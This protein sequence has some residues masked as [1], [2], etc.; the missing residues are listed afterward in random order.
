LWVIDS[1]G[2]RLVKIANIVGRTITLI[3]QSEDKP[4]I[5]IEVG[6]SPQDA[7]WD[8]TT[9]WVVNSGDNSVMK[10]D[11]QTLEIIAEYDDIGNGPYKLVYDGEGIWVAIRNGDQLARLDKETGEVLLTIDLGEGRPFDLAW[12][13]EFIWVALDNID[14]VRKY[15][16]LSGDIV[17]SPVSVDDGLQEII[18]QDGS[19]WVVSKSAGT[20]QQ[21]DPDSMEIIERVL[22]GDDPV[23]LVY[24]EGDIW[25]ATESS[26][27]IQLVDGEILSLFAI[28]RETETE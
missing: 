21:I 25:V 19:V 7:L 20:L 6:R 8:G 11:P 5:E 17:G 10:V 22:I 4:I 12:D 16:I 23:A 2:G 18:V 1:T 9:L 26:N 3:E 24:F 13:G 28:S 27:Q 15:D 14:E